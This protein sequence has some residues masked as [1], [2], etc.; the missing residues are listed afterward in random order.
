M[1]AN[2]R[3]SDTL[4]RPWTRRRLAF[5]QV[6]PVSG[7]APPMPNGQAWSTPGHAE[8]EVVSRG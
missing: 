5:D 6:L 3:R 1:V 4:L 8:P 2:E 7:S